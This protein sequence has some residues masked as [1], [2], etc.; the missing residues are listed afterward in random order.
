MTYSEL[1]SSDKKVIDQIAKILYDEGDS[2]TNFEWI[3][4]PLQDKLLR[5][6]KRER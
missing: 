1:S 2:S 5:L 4:G 3:I 6:E